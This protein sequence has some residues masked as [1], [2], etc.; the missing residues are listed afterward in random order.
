MIRIA[1]AALAV[2]LPALAHAGDA[3]R[4]Q[5]LA[6]RWCTECHVVGPNQPGGDAGPAFTSLMKNDARSEF[7]IRRW[8]FQPHPPMPDFNLTAPEI[9]DLMA[10]INSVQE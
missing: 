1:L 4:G 7:D 3:E 8:L 6:E 2:A 9:D 10:Y 5:A